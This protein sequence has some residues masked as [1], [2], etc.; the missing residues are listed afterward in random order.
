MIRRILTVVLISLPIFMFGQTSGKISGKVAD[1]DGKPLQGANIIVEGTSIGTASN[2]DGAFVIL[3]VPVGTYT[4]RCDY[5]GY[6]AL[7]ISN[8]NVS[9]G[10]TTGQ[11][12]GLEKSAIEGAVVEVRAEKPLI[13]KNSTNTVRIIGSETIENLPLRGVESIIA[14]QTGT[15]SDDGN[16]YVRGSR[17]GDVAY[18]VDGVYMNNAWSLNNTSTVSNSA[19]E[20]IQFQSGGFSAEY[21]NVNGGVV[22]TTTKSGGSEI[23]IS[24]EMITGMGTS[25][26]GYEDGLYSNG[27]NL[28]NINFGGPVT[29]KIKFYLSYEGRG[30]DDSN[31]SSHPSY[32]MDR[33]EFDATKVGFL[34]DEDGEKVKDENE[35]IFIVD[36]SGSENMYLLDDNGDAT[37][38]LDPSYNENYGMVL[39][40]FDCDGCFFDYH[41]VSRYDEEGVLTSETVYSG[42]N[43]FQNVYGSKTNSGSDRTTITGNLV[44]DFNPL[45]LKVGGSLNSNEGRSY[46]HSYSLVNSDNNPIYENSS[47]SLYANVTYS[48]SENSFIKLNASSFKY[49]SESGDVN[50]GDDFSMYGAVDDDSYL[51]VPG[52]NQ[53]SISQTAKF[54]SYGS[55]YDDYSY[56]ETSYTGLKAD[57]LN[58]LNDHELRAG[59][60]YR[61]NTIKYY[62][63]AQPME[64]A[65]QEH[66]GSLDVETVMNDDWY[67]NVYHDA[68]VDNLGFT[69]DYTD[70][71]N[72]NRYQAPGEPTIM[73][74]YFQDKIEL[75]DLVVNAG[76]RF[77]Y[78]DP[79]T[80]APED[81]ND[82]H[83]IANRE[84]D[85][86]ASN[87]K[88]VDPY[89]SIS[90]RLGFSFPVTDQTKFHAQYGKFTQHPILR[91]LYLSDTALSAD[92]TQGN[93]TVSANPSLKPE[94]TTQYEVGFTQQIGNSAALDITGFFKE[95]RNYT[96]L[97]NRIDGHVNGNPQVWAQYQNGDFGIVKGLSFNLNMR[98]VKGIMTN[99]SYTVSFA[100]GTGSDAASNFNI[101]WI[102]DIYPTTINP[103]EYDQ[104]HTGS[105]MVDYRSDKQSGLFAD[106]GM[107]LLYQFGSG[108]A[109]TPAQIYSVVHDRD[110]LTPVASI[111]S[112]YKPW[113]STLDLKINKGLKLAGYRTTI[114]L[115][116]NNLFNTNN[117]DEVYAGSGEAGTDAWLNTSNGKAWVDGHGNG[118]AYYNAKISDPRNWDAPRQVRLGLTFGL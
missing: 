104:R 57:Y 58:Q 116:V 35:N 117:V 33:T 26:S 41:S 61:K 81:W 77:D 68:Y 96:M 17:A 34:Y 112:A 93:A 84:I 18:Y 16:I 14:L 71:E 101:A 74:A 9:S 56:N 8:V 27:Y 5:I 65:W 42:Y 88:K 102:G 118:V 105:V 95:V 60:D 20:E 106:M 19:M 62:R 70:K 40:G 92:L 91:N 29:E 67:Y 10:L 6:S 73:G 28:Y 46:I 64:I 98:R 87:F 12:F 1:A 109:Y 90:P 69:V 38:D 80:E 85:R 66:Q 36:N 114:Y 24:G 39:D 45:K 108:T 72:G 30:I 59:F 79:N 11:D 111:N 99:V 43:N 83:L 37:E 48:I 49:T 78:F 76:I 55:V 94:E 13:N 32:S 7:I 31:P 23:Q 4:L 52:Q 2:Q 89:S 115:L 113:T 3:D 75:Q 22:N 110:W 107:N 86:E 51:V 44:F 25:G 100:E 47:L 103:L 15:V 50:F 82:I 97:A 53:S 21:G 63:I 54:S